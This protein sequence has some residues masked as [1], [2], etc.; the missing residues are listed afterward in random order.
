MF[1]FALATC[2][3]AQEYPA[4]IQA[5]VGKGIAIQGPLSAPPGFTGF[6]GEY[7]GRKM[8]IYVLPD[9]KHMVI[10]TLFD[11]TATDLTQ[12]PLQEATTPVLDA[13]LW[14]ELAKASWIAE[15]SVKPKRIVYVFTDTECPYCHRL[16]QAT[17][18]LLAGGDVQVRHI[19]VAVIA[20]ASLGRAAAILDAASPAQALHQHESAFGH[21]PIKPESAVPAATAKRIK[22]N[23]DLMARLGIHGTPATIYKSPAGKIFSLQGLPPADR[24]KTIFGS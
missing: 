6:V 13:S 21:S 11:E 22:A 17:Q 7:D 16:W 2:A 15:G 1:V 9:G 19:I 10:G 3:S 5:L 23:I 20:P 14:A 8:P 24:I 18:P 12:A 4:P